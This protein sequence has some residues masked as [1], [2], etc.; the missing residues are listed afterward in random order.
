MAQSKQRRRRKHKGTQAGTVRQ[1]RSTA[2]ASGRGTAE[3]RRVERQ[4]SP[5]TWRGSITRGAIAAGAL[6][7]L[8]A[9]ILR[10][11][12]GEAISLCAVAMLLYVPAFHAVDSFLYG[13]RQARR[14]R[15]D[16]QP[17]S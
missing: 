4:N 3:Q 15:E 16:A 8:L 6:F 2:R 5:P 9:L 13:R 12:V 14:A 1:R 10:A 17:P 11:P 7:L